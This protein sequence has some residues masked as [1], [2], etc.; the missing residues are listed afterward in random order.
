MRTTEGQYRGHKV[1]LKAGLEGAAPTEKP[2][3]RRF[4]PGNRKQAIRADHEREQAI[5]DNTN[6]WSA[7][8]ED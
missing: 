1:M 5:H 4:R 3:T 6:A 7:F 8:G 2:L